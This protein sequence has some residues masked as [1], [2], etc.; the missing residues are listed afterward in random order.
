[1]G[2]LTRRTH[3]EMSD[4]LMKRCFAPHARWITISQYLPYKYAQMHNCLRISQEDWDA[5]LGI[6]PGEQLAKEMPNLL[7]WGVAEI[8]NFNLQKI[9]DYAWLAGDEDG[10][11]GDDELTEENIVPFVLSCVRRYQFNPTQRPLEDIVRRLDSLLKAPER[12]LILERYLPYGY[13]PIS[14]YMSEKDWTDYRFKFPPHEVGKILLSG[15]PPQQKDYPQWASFRS[16]MKALRELAWLDGKDELADELLDNPTQAGINR[17]HQAY[18]AAY[19]LEVGLISY[20][21][22]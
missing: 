19:G 5:Y 12:K 18:C 4:R 8:S 6:D 17:F 11:G 22:S 14:E 7:S 16:N 15:F 1:M 13:C 20:R 2:N 21:D 10:I 3:A 9:I